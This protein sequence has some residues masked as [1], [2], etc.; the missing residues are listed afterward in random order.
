MA[1]KGAEKKKSFEFFPR[2][3]LFPAAF[4]NREAAGFDAGIWGC[5]QLSD[6]QGSLSVSVFGER[7]RSLRLSRRCPVVSG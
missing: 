2:S 5:F 1:E 4:R 7:Q 3:R 6:L